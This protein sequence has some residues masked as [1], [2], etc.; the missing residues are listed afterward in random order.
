[1]PSN[2]QKALEE[3]LAA[4]TDRLREVEAEAEGKEDIE[5]DAGAVQEQPR[6]DPG[7]PGR[8][9]QGTVEEAGRV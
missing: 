7:R 5:A 6:P 3:E 1:M 9:K 4:V 2:T 8:Q